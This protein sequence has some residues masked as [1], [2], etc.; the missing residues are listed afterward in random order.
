MSNVAS[1]ENC[2]R[3]YE[4][5]GWE[6]CWLT[7]A[8]WRNGEYVITDLEQA[9]ASGYDQKTPAYDA[10]YLLRKL[11]KRVESQYPDCQLVL[12]PLD[13]RWISGYEAGQD[14]HYLSSDDTPE[15]ALTLLAIQLFEQGVLTKEIE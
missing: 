6:G 3:L 12:Y 8:E 4:L 5:S 10:G 7:H 9:I 11:P 15:D 13:S 2:K 1:L 14:I